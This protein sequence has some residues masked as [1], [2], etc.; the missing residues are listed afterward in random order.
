ML[1]L[2]NEIDSN[3]LMF[4]CGTFQEDQPLAL[5]GNCGEGKRR[6]GEQE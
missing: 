4:E 1:W 3:I 6:R 5:S 2:I